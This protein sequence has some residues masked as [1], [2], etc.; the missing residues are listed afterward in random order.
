MRNLLEYILQQ[1]KRLVFP[2]GAGDA[3]K[4][5]T[6]EDHITAEEKKAEYIAYQCNELGFDLN[7]MTIPFTDMFQTFQMKTYNIGGEEEYCCAGQITTD[8]D[9]YFLKQAAE[10]RREILDKYISI[11]QLLKK[12]TD[13]PVTIGTFGPLTLAGH[14]MGVEEILIGILKQPDFIHHLLTIITDCLCNWHTEIHKHGGDFVWIAEPVGMMISPT[15]FFEFLTPYVKKIYN[16]SPEAGF[17]HIPGDTRHLLTPMCHCGAQCLSLD[18]YVGMKYALKHVPEN[19]VILGD[20]DSRD[21]LEK[22]PAEIREAVT[23]LNQTIESHPNVIVSTG[24]GITTESPFENIT[25]L[26]TA[27]EEYG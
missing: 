27:T 23:Y 1:K 15:Q 20:I 3:I 16:C 4:N 9:L 25:I 2:I 18:H 7:C 10:N 13:K 5:C 21:I 14:L 19:I 11:L 8:N 22:S 12:K 6:F 24:G 26:I 17:L